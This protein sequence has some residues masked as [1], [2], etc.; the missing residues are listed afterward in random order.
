MRVCWLRPVN[1]DNW[2]GW[3]PSFGATHLLQ[4][5]TAWSWRSRDFLQVKHFEYSRYRTKTGHTCFPNESHYMSAIFLCAFRKSLIHEREKQELCH[6]KRRML[7]DTRTD[8]TGY[9]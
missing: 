1:S 8:Q 6:K 4:H 3:R 2:N 7:Y 9:S 5:Q